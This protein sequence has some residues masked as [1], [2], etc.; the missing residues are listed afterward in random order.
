M[1]DNSIINEN[2][3]VNLSLN[4]NNN[5][6]KTKKDNIIINK[7]IKFENTMKKIMITKIIKKM[8]TKEVMK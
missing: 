3:N 6:D 2:N 7:N 5:E 8:W 4:D 1:N